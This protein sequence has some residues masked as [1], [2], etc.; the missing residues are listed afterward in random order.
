MSWSDS[1]RFA[2][3][4]LQVV[5]FAI[6]SYFLDHQIAG[7]RLTIGHLSITTLSAHD[8]RYVGMLYDKTYTYDFKA[9]TVSIRLHLPTSTLPR[10]LTFAAIDLL[11]NS[12]TTDISVARLDVTFWI[13]PVLFRITAGPWLNVVLDDFRIRIFKSKATPFYIQRLRQNLVGAILTGEYLRV[14]DAWTNAQFSGLT[15]LVSVNG[16]THASG[17]GFGLGKHANGGAH[18]AADGGALHGSGSHDDCADSD[19]TEKAPKLLPRDREEIRV[20]AYARQLH[21]NNTEG[22]IY[23]FQRLDAQLRRD[24]DADAGTFVLV[25]EESRWV[26][27]HWPYQRTMVLSWWIQLASAILTFPYDV[28]HTFQHPMGSV[29]LYVLRADVTFDEYRIRDAELV[30]QSI[31]LIREKAYMYNIDAS[32]ILFDTLAKLIAPR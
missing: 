18:E 31:S 9:S 27:V 23:T 24:W 6:T 17:N 22:R 26:R 14:D 20:S 12:S 5:Y 25:A 16:D 28:F 2:L 8:V 13:F 29:N 19:P 1:L 10:W 32:E 4:F 3:H 7:H 21:I 15:E 11:Y 30:I